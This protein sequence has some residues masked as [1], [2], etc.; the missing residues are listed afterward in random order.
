V[1]RASTSQ[2]VPKAKQ[3]STIMDAMSNVELP[4]YDAWNELDALSTHTTVDGIYGDPAGDH[5]HG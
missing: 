5:R 4:E 3:I 2:R 1:A